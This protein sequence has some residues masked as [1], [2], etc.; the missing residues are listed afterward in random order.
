MDLGEAIETP[1]V[2][3]DWE[4]TDQA[5]KAYILNK[6]DINDGQLTIQFNGHEY[7]F[8]ANQANNTALN[9]DAVIQRLVEKIDSLKT[10]INN[11]KDSIK[12]LEEG[13]GMFVC[14][15]SKAKDIDGNKYETVVINSQCWM[16]TNLRV[17]KTAKGNAIANDATLSETVPHYYVAKDST[18]MADLNASIYGYLYNWEAAK[19]VCPSGWHLPTAAEWSTLTDYLVSLDVYKCSS[20]V[21]NLAKA[22]ASSEGWKVRTNNNYQCEVGYSQSGNNATGFSAYPAGEKNDS[23][24]KKAAR[25]A[26]FWLYNGS[27]STCR[28]LKYDGEKV[29]TADPNPKFGLS[30]RC[31]RN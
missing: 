20:N 17:T 22:L 8:T 5:S 25:E 2:Q 7:T 19:Q 11:I 4:E 15:V 9:I 23:S 30:V 14:G 16:K 10:I 24:E 21:E 27:E 6:P 29:Y 13:G 28:Y 3:S 31:I 18:G 12:V 26:N 1:Q